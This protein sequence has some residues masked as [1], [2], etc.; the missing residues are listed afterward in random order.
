LRFTT[1]NFIFINAC[2]CSPYVTSSLTRGWVYLLQLLLVPASTV[3]LRSESRGTHDHILLS[4]SRD[5]PD[6]EGQV[7]ILYPPATGWPGYTPRHRI[8]V[9]SS[10]ATRRATVEVFDPPAHGILFLSLYYS[11]DYTSSVHSSPLRISVTVRF[12]P[13]YGLWVE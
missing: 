7:P 10:P 5:S 3:I 4:Q 8:P 12:I 13:S 11:L 9:S 6:L 2:G 1:S